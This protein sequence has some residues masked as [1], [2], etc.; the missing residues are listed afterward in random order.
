MLAICAGIS[1]TN[2]KEKLTYI[3]DYAFREHSININLFDL[4]D[5]VEEEAI[6]LFNP[7]RIS[8]S[9]RRIDKKILDL[10]QGTRTQLTATVW[11]K[12]KSNISDNNI[13]SIHSC[14]RW[15]KS[16]MPILLVDHIK[17]L[18]PDVCFTITREANEIQKV[19]ERDSKW[20]GKLSVE[21]ILIW[22][23]EEILAMNL[24][25]SFLFIP[26]EIFSIN[27][28]DEKI[29]SY[30]FSNKINKHPFKPFKNGYKTIY[31]SST[32]GTLSKEYL[33]A[34]CEWAKTIMSKEISL[35][36]MKKFL[37]T[38]KIAHLDKSPLIRS[39]KV[40]KV[41]NEISDG[42]QFLK[43]GSI[44][45]FD[46]IGPLVITTGRICQID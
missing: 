33:E 14:F 7:S 8:M 26:H 2:K 16:I 31:I 29:T 40:L 10:S 13:I 24:L 9:K 5:M 15:N 32:P 37:L 30:L 12:I 17:Q 34:F 6:K 23:N 45:Q 36:D 41:I 39:Q 28:P 4:G 43:N 44:K 3:Q 1:G 20:R 18:N 19:L 11:E 35:L 21:E 46:D 42:D 22:Q 38:Y 27:T 25:S